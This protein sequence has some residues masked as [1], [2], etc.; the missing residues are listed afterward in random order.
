VTPA[1]RKADLPG[2]DRAAGSEDL[3]ESLKRKSIRKKERM[4]D[5]I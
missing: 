1:E 5:E 4:R 3:K 2:P